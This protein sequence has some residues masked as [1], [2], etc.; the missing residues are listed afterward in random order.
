MHFLFYMET[1]NILNILHFFFHWN[2]LILGSQMNDLYFEL[3]K[4]KIKLNT[5]ID[6]KLDQLI[7]DQK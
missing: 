2:F 5:K 3:C 7:K 6:I 1:F 4:L